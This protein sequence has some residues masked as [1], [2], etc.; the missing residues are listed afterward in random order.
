MRAASATRFRPRT[1][2][3]PGWVLTNTPRLPRTL[4]PGPLP[5]PSRRKAPD[6]GPGQ[7]LYD[8]R[9]TARGLSRPILP[10]RR[11]AGGR[12]G[13]RACRW[14]I[15][16]RGP[17]LAPVGS[18]VVRVANLGPLGSMSARSGPPTLRKGQRSALQS[19]RPSFPHG[20]AALGGRARVLTFPCCSTGGDSLAGALLGRLQAGQAE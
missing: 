18:R 17:T 20:L 16:A 12:V 5:L 4:F 1:W 7:S 3:R 11:P 2:R 19:A 15:E 9:G 8:V 10:L 6:Q 13:F 14:C